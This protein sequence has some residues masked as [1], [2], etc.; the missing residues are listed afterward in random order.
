MDFDLSDEQRLL[1]DS[2]DRLV[3]D[4]YADFTRRK[5]YA[6]EPNGWSARLWATY[7][8]LG[9]L[10]LPFDEADGGSG[11]GPVENMLVMEAF[12]RGL[13]LEPY[14]ASVILGGGLLRASGSSAVIPKVID[15]S[16]RL[17]FAHV[18]RQA[19]YDLHDVATTARRDGDG[20]MIDGEKGVVLHGDSATHVL[21]S[22]RTA[23]GRREAAGLTLFAVDADVAGVSRRSYPTQDGL[24]AAEISFER[25]RVP[26]G[27][28][29]GE[30]D[31]GA[32]LIDAAIDDTLAALCAEAVGAMAALQALTLEYLKQ[33]RQ[34]GAAIGSFQALQH[35]AVDMMIA[36]EQ[37]RSMA[38]YAA[39]MADEPDPAVRRSAIAAAKVQVNRS[40]RSVGQEAIQLHGGIGMTMEYKAGHYFKRLAMIETLFGDTEHHLRVVAETL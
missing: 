1:K 21:V 15:G 7:A 25:V 37:A 11:G 23:G 20:W 39:M 31:N 10:G 40:A 38:M 16:A 19:R 12:G 6:E 27:A 24:R 3:D 4:N 35:R 32:V 33:R 28:V 34:F 8:E 14:L 13:V 2:V 22:C 17:A 26:A 18:E 30:V 9:L 36:V 5:G 29:V